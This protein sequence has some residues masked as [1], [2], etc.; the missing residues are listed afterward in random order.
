[1]K[2]AEYIDLLRQQGKMSFG[3]DQALE[4]LQIT[5]GAM[6]MSLSRLRKKGS[7]VTPYKS[8]GAKSMIDTSL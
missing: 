6:S 3:S 4:A 5:P 2:L 1:M 8:Q 7:L